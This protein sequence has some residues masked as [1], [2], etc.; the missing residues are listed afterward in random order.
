MNKRMIGIVLATMGCGG[1]HH[2]ATPRGPIA[3]VRGQTEEVSPHDRQTQVATFTLANV[4]DADLILGPIQTSCGCSSAKAT[5]DV[6]PPGTTARIVAEARPR[7]VGMRSVVI[8]VA[9]NTKDQPQLALRWELVGQADPPQLRA[10]PP[11]FDVGILRVGQIPSSGSIRFDVLEVRGSPPFI[12]KATCDQ[13]FVRVTG[14][15]VD[16]IGGD[17]HL[18]TRKYRFDLDWLAAP[19]IGPIHNQVRLESR[20]GPVRSWQT[21][22]V[23]GNVL[24][25]LRSIPSALT[26]KPADTGRVQ[27]LTFVVVAAE[28]TDDLDLEC[29]GHDPAVSIR[30]MQRQGDRI[31][32]EADFDPIK[33]GQPIAPIRLRTTR[34]SEAIVEIPIH[35][36]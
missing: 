2:S 9:T 30:R 15:M 16:E 35:Q 25:T 33:Q 34:P 4:G 31:V 12:E 22:P 21:I 7:S 8:T 28:S 6:V 18:V 11:T 29:I 32:V 13:S 1:C 17:A 24:P 19:P 36:L 23:R 26:I 20:G 5:P 3:A 14:G 10:A 27:S